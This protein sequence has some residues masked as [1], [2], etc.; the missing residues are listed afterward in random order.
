MN[1]ED[2]WRYLCDLSCEFT[3]K[4]YQFVYS[5]SQNMSKI[6]QF[7]GAFMPMWLLYLVF[8][9]ILLDA[10]WNYQDIIIQKLFEGCHGLADRFRN[11]INSSVK[12]WNKA[13]LRSLSIH[14]RCYTETASCFFQVE[15]H[16][17]WEEVIK[18]VQI[19]GYKG[20][21]QKKSHSVEKSRFR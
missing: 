13:V 21:M 7:C 8:L 11:Q 15:P 2:Y 20:N 10:N 14:T 16:H 9:L 4:T 5:N 6:Y 17:T 12:T 1:D 19:V 3:G 18:W